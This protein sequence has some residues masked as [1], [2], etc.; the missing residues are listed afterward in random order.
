[1]EALVRGCVALKVV[2][3]AADDELITPLC[4]RLWRALRPGIVFSHLEQPAQLWE[5]LQDMERE[6][7]VVW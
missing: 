1:V 7:I 5:A 6:E 4:R 2:H 3:V